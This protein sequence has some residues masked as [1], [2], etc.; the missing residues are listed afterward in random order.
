MYIYE[1][2]TEQDKELYEKVSGFWFDKRW[3]KWCVDREHEIYIVCEG[4]HGVETPVVFN[5]CF[6]AH[7]FKFM[8]PEP[9]IQYGGEPEVIVRIPADLESDRSAIEDMIKRAF[10]K[11]QEFLIMEVYPK[12]LM[13]I[14]LILKVF[15]LYN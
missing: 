3:S 4:K 7:L 12:V 11:Q 14:L 15:D 2:V 10:G 9:D 13:I 5:I 1:K 6:K 8:I